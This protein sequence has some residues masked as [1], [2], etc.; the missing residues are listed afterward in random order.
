MF[1]TLVTGLLTSAL[2]NYIEPKCFSSDK[3]NVAVWSGYVVLTELEVKPEV[4]ADLPAVRLVRGLVGSIELK[5]PWNRLQSD[6]VVATV[7]DVYLLL[8]TEDD[9]DAVM[10]AMDEFTLKKKL[11]EELYVQAKRQEDAA[12]SSE[13]GFT[14]RLVNKIIDNLELHIRRIH[15]RVE[16]HSSGDHPFAMGITI[17]SVHV[18]STNSNW[19]PSYVDTSKSNEPRI[20]KIVELNHL[21]VYCN[22]DCEL[23]RDRPLNFET[24][25]AEQF[26]SAFSRAIP[27]RFDERHYHHM[28][29]YPSQQQHHFLLKPID[30]SARLVNRDV[31]DANVPKFEVDVNIS[32]VAFRLE[33][34]QYCDILY[35]ASALQIPEHYTKYQRYRKF[36]PRAAVFDE[37]ADWWKYAITSVQED[38][39]TKKQQWT[40]GFMK[41]RRE[42]RKHYVSLWHQ[43]SR[44]LLELT[45]VDYVLSDSED[46]D[47]AADESD[48][49]EGIGSSPL[50]HANVP[51][52]SSL[53]IDF[54]LEEIERRRSVEDVLFFRYLGDLE[55]R[56][57]QA[58]R[59]PRVRRR[60]PTPPPHKSSAF[61]DSE[62]VDTEVTESSVPAEVRY[63]SWG[64]WMFGWTSKLATPTPDGES[65]QTPH[66]IIPEV[67]LR[68]LFKILEEPSR[69]S[70]KR[71][72]K[73]RDA[74][75]KDDASDNESQTE[76]SELYRVTVSLQRGS[77]TLA[78]DPETNKTLLR[79]DP[80]YGRKY[81]P[82]EFLL[83]T[84][85]Q[86]QVAAVGRDETVVVDVSLQ[87]IEAFDE[88]A[89]SS[90]FSRLLSR[91]QTIRPT[92]D[93][94]DVNVNK[95]SGVV[96][97]MSYEMNPPNSSA[98]A[99]LFVHMEP[100]E[101]VFSPT[102]RCWGRLAKFMDT[103][104]NLGL[105]EE[106]EVASFNDIVNLKARTEAKL[107]YVMENRIALAVDLRIQAPVL[108]IPES[109][110]DYNCARLVVDLGRINFR[111]NR[112]SQMDS[113]SI[114][115]G[116]TGG[117]PS[118]RSAPGSLAVQSPSHFRGVNPNTSFV[119]QLYDEAERGEGAIRWKE[120]FYDKFSLSIANI[121]VLLIPYGKTSRV[122]DD[123]TG[124]SG[125]NY[126]SVS[127]PPYLTDIYDEEQEYELVERFNINVTVRMSILPLDATLTRFYVHADLPALTFNLSLE[128]YFQLVALADRFSVA[129]AEAPKQT[130]KYSDGDFYSPDGAYGNADI[131]VA[132]SNDR[133]EAMRRG[134]FLS[135]SA[136]KKFMLNDNESAGPL[137]AAGALP[138]DPGDSDGNS[139]VESD[140]TWFSI[141]SGNL[142][143]RRTT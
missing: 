90:A 72:H 35:L 137:S 89:E 61:S 13:D 19:Q 67:E 9:I 119:Q 83:G 86:L 58:S 133:Y 109:D 120:E 88:S 138:D 125:L 91:K 122:Q 65:S 32:E 77:L 74:G 84:F 37:P 50:D 85:S 130:R 54:G 80:S 143:G 97:L 101:I 121:H 22:P 60:L 24:C 111:T 1:E 45:N 141:T 66:R 87:S 20:F 108:I 73:H 105:W 10:R 75:G 55:V 78:S 142:D 56:K 26:S 25:S 98:D 71:N 23:Q 100:L 11:L 112:L 3:I 8:R 135:T 113:E 95:L 99:S 33:E 59:A 62:S 36:R 124:S 17:E 102:A 115:L 131:G 68:E 38:L 41:D 134:S 5:I 114:S 140:D 16:D 40:W 47:E 52:L 92:G 129:N 48:E 2:G 30:A 15:V 116:S 44:L 28:Q 4:V 31:F 106:L 76:L 104:A 21:S 103:P 43:K 70:K 63:R 14:A 49:R 39:K 29:L 110:T 123:D 96:F 27:K 126:P 118:N 64:A 53:E 132:D 57:F 107:D 18:Q 46:N 42:D 34:S 136:L 128:K 117:P 7:D 94:D 82:T 6:S 12:A 127:L 93:T 51:K 79:N 69:R 81:A 139:S